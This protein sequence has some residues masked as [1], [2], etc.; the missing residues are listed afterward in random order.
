[1]H[2][3]FD[4]DDSDISLSVEKFLFDGE[5]RQCP[6]ET[7]PGWNKDFGPSYLQRLHD[8]RLNRCLR[9]RNNAR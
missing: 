4:N 2:N 1:M 9:T 3:D 6:L 7:L 8:S 5:L